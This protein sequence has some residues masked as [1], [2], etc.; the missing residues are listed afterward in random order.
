[1]YFQKIWLTPFITIPYEKFH[2]YGIRFSHIYKIP[3]I[4]NK[5]ASILIGN[6]GF[7]SKKPFFQIKS[8]KY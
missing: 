2:D 7:Q 4:L 8:L 6:V 1:M 3:S 5:I